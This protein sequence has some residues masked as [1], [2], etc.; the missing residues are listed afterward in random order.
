MGTSDLGCGHPTRV[1]GLGCLRSN[2]GSLPRR[3]HSVQML[4]KAFG[5]SELDSKDYMGVL[6]RIGGV[7]V[8]RRTML[9]SMLS[10]QQCDARLSWMEI[11]GCLQGAHVTS[12]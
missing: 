7:R 2:P 6:W 12:P 10:E 3:S 5:A 11:L 8:L 9:C 1:D 4:K